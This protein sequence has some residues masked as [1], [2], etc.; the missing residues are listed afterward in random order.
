MTDSLETF[1]KRL[2]EVDFDVILAGF[3]L[4]NWTA[5]DALER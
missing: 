1:R 5:L 4:R 2:E 3:N